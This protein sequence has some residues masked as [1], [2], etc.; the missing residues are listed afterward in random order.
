MER[1]ARIDEKETTIQVTGNEV[2]AWTSD[3]VIYRK[4]RKLGWT[5]TADGSQSTWFKAPTNALTFRRVGIKKKVPLAPEQKKA[6]RDRFRK[7]PLRDSPPLNNKENP[8]R[9][10]NVE[11]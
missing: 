4:L 5:I 1:S 9:V 8:T 3:L 11:G 7:G 2:T 10:D 6:I